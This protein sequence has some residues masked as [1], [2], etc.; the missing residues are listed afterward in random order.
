MYTLCNI[1]NRRYLNITL[2]RMHKYLPCLHNPHVSGHLFAIQ[3]VYLLQSCLKDLQQSNR[4]LHLSTFEIKLS[5]YSKI[6][7][8]H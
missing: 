4:F 8:F 5:N 3:K 2:K 1:Y 7:S 6:F